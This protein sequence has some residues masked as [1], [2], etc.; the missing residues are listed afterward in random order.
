MDVR[1][2][3]VGYPHATML[4]DGED[5]VA[6]CVDLIAAGLSA[7]PG[8]A[9]LLLGV[10]DGVSILIGPAEDYPEGVIDADS[11]SMSFEELLGFDSLEL[12]LSEVN[13]WRC[14]LSLTDGVELEDW[15]RL[16][17]VVSRSGLWDPETSSKVV[18]AALQYDAE[19]AAGQLPHGLSP[20][21][22][23]PAMEYLASLPEEPETA[24]DADTRM[25]L[26][27]ALQMGGV[28]AERIDE[29]PAKVSRTT[30]GSCFVVAQYLH[31]H[32]GS[33]EVF[34]DGSLTP[35]SVVSVLEFDQR[36]DQLIT[37]AAPRSARECMEEFD[38]FVADLESMWRL[39]YLHRRNGQLCLA[40]TAA[41]LY[42][43]GV[44]HGL[45]ELTFVSGFLKE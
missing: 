37:D 13:D 14:V 3:N 19:G 32:G 23:I 36:T 6:E 9:V 17:Q 39:G 18:G 7:V 10:R 41:E 1:A 30:L 38:G 4:L 25:K 2:L 15:D 31:D 8:P 44:E 11:Y 26:A 5:Y 24:E 35:E 12:V 16:P 45:G 40:Q 20:T 33:I 34:E 27:F 42:T 43:Q 22:V 21:L 29:V 28:G